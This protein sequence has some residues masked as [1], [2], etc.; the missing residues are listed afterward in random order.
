LLQGAGVVKVLKSLR[1]RWYG[2]MARMNNEGISKQIVTTRMEGIRKRGN[3]RKRWTDEV[4]EDL[5][6]IGKKN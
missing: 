1:L 5:K 4:K 3:P 6:I 2:H